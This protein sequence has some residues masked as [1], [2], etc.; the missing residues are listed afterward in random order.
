MGLPRRWAVEGCRGAGRSLAQR[1]VADGE[2]VLDVPA[3]LAAR[4]RVYSQ[5][6]RPQDRQGTMRC[7][8]AWPPSTAAGSGPGGAWE[9][10]L[11]SLRLLC[12]RREELCALRTQAACLL[13]R[14]LAGLTPGG[15]RR[16]L[17]AGK[18]GALPARIRPGDE[19]ARIRLQLAEDHLAGIRALDARLKNGAQPRSALSWPRRAPR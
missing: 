16:E 10:C 15:M 6:A 8:S 5:G 4:V 1:L 7:P 11:V 18:A 3:K 12:D 2:V 17:T 19:V 13:H 9:T 14:L